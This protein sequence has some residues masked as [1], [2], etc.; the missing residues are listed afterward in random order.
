LWLRFVDFGTSPTVW[1][2][3]FVDFALASVPP[4]ASRHEG[5]IGFVSSISFPTIAECSD[6]QIRL[7]PHPTT[8]FLHRFAHPERR[9]DVPVSLIIETFA[10]SAPQI[11]K[12]LRREC[13]SAMAIE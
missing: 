13:P 10:G 8:Y 2:L 6:A 4:P 1:W 3:R 5:S 12:N 7:V 11:R 9:R